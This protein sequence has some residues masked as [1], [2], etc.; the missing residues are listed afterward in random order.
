ML[1]VG[2]INS[3]GAEATS[4]ALLYVH[5]EDA[6]VLTGDVEV[7]R[8]SFSYPVDT[9]VPCVRVHSLISVGFDWSGD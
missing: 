9:S 8:S 3:N 1:T 7:F 6:L 2:W 5:A 4:T